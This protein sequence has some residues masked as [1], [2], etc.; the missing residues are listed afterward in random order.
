M[1]LTVII[2]VYN[3]EKTIQKAIVSVV[4]QLLDDM[5]CMV[6]NDGSTDHTEEVV[7]ECIAKYG[8]KL[9]YYKKQKK[10]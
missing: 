6:I 8:K 2:P 3:R 9:T 1:K 10:K 7:Q 5:E 4:E